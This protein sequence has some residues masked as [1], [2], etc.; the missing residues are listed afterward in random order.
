MK[1][2][3]VLVLGLIST[4]TWGQTVIY[5][6]D[7]QSGLPVN[8]TLLNN[9]GLT[10]DASVS[11]F[12]DAWISL[13]DPGNPSDTIMGSTSFFNPTGQADR[14]L[15]T[16]AI[17]LGSY[18]NWAYWEARSHDPSHPDTYY[19][20]VS[21]TDTQAASFTDTL[22]SYAGE[23]PDWTSREGDLSALGL[24][25][26]TIYLAFV[27]RTEDGFKLY[28][29]DIRV[30]MEDPSSVSELTSIRLQAYPN[31]VS[32]ILQITCNQAIESIEIL[33]SFGQPVGYCTSSSIAVSNLSTGTYFARV[34]G[35]FGSTTLRFVKR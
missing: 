9:D 35:E 18:G 8:Y 22:F 11:E 13:S 33:N 17:T 1:K 10:P 26:Q 5:S 16:P 4:T 32:E 34:T 6:E 29:D 2:G 27:N 12:S 7:F 28:V 19:V 3:I 25:N 23:H 14:W 20:L 31:P 21:S 30:E 24:D 15:I